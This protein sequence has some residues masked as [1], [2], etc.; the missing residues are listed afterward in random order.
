MSSRSPRRSRRYSSFKRSYAWKSSSLTCCIAHSEL[1]QSVSTFSI[2]RSTNKRS[3][4]TSRWASMRNDDSGPLFFL[5]SDCMRFNCSRDFSTEPL[6]RYTSLRTLSAPSLELKDTNNGW[7]GGRGVQMGVRGEGTRRC[8]IFSS[9]ILEIRGQTQRPDKAKVC[10][11]IQL[12]TRKWLRRPRLHRHPL[13]E[14]SPLSRI[15][16]TA[17]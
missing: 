10:P 14:H 9:L 3:C 16:P 17:E 8:R 1:M 11:L 4:K 13:P 7:E 15:P 2:I 6:N 12:S 5:S